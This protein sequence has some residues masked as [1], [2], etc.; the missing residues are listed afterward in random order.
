MSVIAKQCGVNF[1]PPS[2][3]LIYE[4]KD[5]SKLR[6]RVMPVRNFS[7]YSDCSRAA[8]RLKHNARHA[9]YLETVSLEQLVRLHTVLRDHMQGLSVEESL[10]VQRSADLHEEDLNKLGDEELKK[11]KA[12]MDELFERN[13]RHKDDPDFVYDL[14]VKFPEN[15]VRETCSWDQSDDEF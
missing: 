12:K 3:I 4:N 2:I 14:Q 10:K 7:Q 1:N 9:P 5:S 13:R 8:E 6:K 15:S 11:R